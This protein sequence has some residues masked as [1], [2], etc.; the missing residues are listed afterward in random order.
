MA[1]PGPLALAGM[2]PGGPKINRETTEKLSR[3]HRG[4]EVRFF[5]SKMWFENNFW[6]D[7]GLSGG[8]K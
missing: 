7:L 1:S 2:A 8:P 4:I 6:R 5:F 3:N